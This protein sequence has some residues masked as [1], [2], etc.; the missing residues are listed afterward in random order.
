MNIKT[1]NKQESGGVTF[2]RF[3]QDLG[4]D[5]SKLLVKVLFRGSTASSASI[6][7]LSLASAV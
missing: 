2:G 6:R 5:H 3:V 1:R 4:G 7:L